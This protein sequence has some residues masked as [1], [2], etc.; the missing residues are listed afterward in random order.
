MSA[1]EVRRPAPIADRV[2]KL[3][4]VSL[5]EAKGAVLVAIKRSSAKE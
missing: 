3:P 5:E 1:D 2:S 4:R